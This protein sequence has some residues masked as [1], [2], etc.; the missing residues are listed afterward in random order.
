MS[1]ENTAEARII[2][3][4][5][6]FNGAAYL[7][8]QLE[9][10]AAQDL[11]P[12]EVFIADDASEDSTGRVVAEFSRA[13]PFPVHFRRNKTRLGVV[14]NYSRL[15][16][17]CR[18]SY[19]ALSDQDDIWLPHRLKSSYRV[20]REAECRYGE[21]RPLLVHSD[22]SVVDNRAR[23]L[24]PSFMALRRIGHCD[25]EPLKR[26]LVQNFVTANTVLVNRALLEAALPFPPGAVM[27]DWWLALVA[28]ATGKIL[29]Q[30]AKP[31]VL[32]RQHEANLVGAGAFYSGRSLARFLDRAGSG[33]ELAAAVN[34]AVALQKHLRRLDLPEPPFLDACLRALQGGGFRAPLTV[35]R[36]GVKKQGLLRNLHFFFLMA[37]AGY[38]EKGLLE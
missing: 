13:A 37:A 10:I 6:T 16:Q 27:H 28:A 19:I 3:A 25:E 21:N 12:A 7:P 36:L 33:K 2:V 24:A 23:L 4:L 26:L 1:G 31:T 9:S 15:L 14:A 38:R 35:L 8:E 20:L 34:Q 30:A 17:R 29:F 32:Y 11:L 22:L 18:A 5:C